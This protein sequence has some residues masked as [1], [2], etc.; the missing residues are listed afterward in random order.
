M[1]IN[2]KQ[3]R[4]L[5]QESIT[6]ILKEGSA[7]SSDW[8]RWD[9]IKETIGADKM[10]DA[11]FN[12]MDQNEIE[13][14]L[15]F[16]E[17]EYDIN[18]GYEEDY[19]DILQESGPNHAQKSIVIWDT[20][21]KLKEKMSVDDILSRLIGRIGADAALKYLKDIEMTEFGAYD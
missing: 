11:I 8:E 21:D 14:M 13:E 5:I 19:D 15:D 16:L 17:Q 12:A 3:L 7:N 10:L 18:S 1:K 2:E 4:K 9:H 6:N 20:L